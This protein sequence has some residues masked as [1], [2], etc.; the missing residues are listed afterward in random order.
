[1]RSV[2]VAT[3]RTARHSGVRGLWKLRDA[4]YAS[5][6]GFRDEREPGGVRIFWELG[7]AT[8][9]C[10][11]ELRDECEPG[12]VCG[13]RELCDATY[14]SCTE[15]RD[16]REPGG[17]RGLFELGDAMRRARPVR[18]VRAGHAE[19]ALA[20]DRARLAPTKPFLRP[21]RSLATP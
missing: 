16:E 11:T 5:C 13:L 12:G 17:M 3:C 18:R 4:I 10:Y 15:L 14:A 1:M 21:K 19:A 8:Y 7:D 20:S 9:A 2:D 6:T